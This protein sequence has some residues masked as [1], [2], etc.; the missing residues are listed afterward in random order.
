MLDTLKALLADSEGQMGGRDLPSVAIMVII[1]GV[2]LF[3]GVQ[4]MSQVVEQTGLAS[5]DPFYNASQSLQTSFDSAFGT[6]GLAVTIVVFAVI[7]VYLYGLR[8]G[9][10]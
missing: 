7:I 2:V 5:G 3:V 1:S 4:I 8:G 10:R 9:G 6:F